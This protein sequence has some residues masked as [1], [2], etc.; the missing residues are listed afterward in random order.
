MDNTT[1][2]VTFYDTLAVQ[3]RHCRAID[4]MQVTAGVHL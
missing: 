4:G 2:G 3:E 1:A